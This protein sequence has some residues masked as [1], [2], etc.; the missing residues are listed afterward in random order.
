MADQTVALSLP[1]IP[2]EVLAFAT[3]RGVSRFLP[4]AISFRF[5]GT[6]AKRRESP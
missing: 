6:L 3:E 5:N 4:V 2:P 1:A